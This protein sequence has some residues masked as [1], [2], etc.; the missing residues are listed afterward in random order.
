MN[1]VQ[2]K[3][4]LLK[5]LPALLLAILLLSVDLAVNTPDTTNAVS[6]LL[7]VLPKDRD[8][9]NSDT[10]VAA[11]LELYQ[12]FDVPE[13]DVSAEPEPETASAGLTQ[14]Q[15][16]Q[17]QGLLQVLYIDDEMY[18]LSAIINQGRYVAV[19]TVT[20]I[21]NEA[22]PPRRLQLKQNDN[23]QQYEV[24]SV[25]SRRITLRYQQRELWLQLFTP[26]P[27]QLAENETMQP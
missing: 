5:V 13:V 18:R 23:L 8:A 6:D 19:L 9:V 26:G 1:T 12:M 20:N 16:Q 7:P 27:A 11:A 2:M 17:Q 25:T 14:E 15:Q 10:K 22:L 4:V 21:N 3:S 24:V